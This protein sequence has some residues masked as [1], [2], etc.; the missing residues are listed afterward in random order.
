MSDD[1]A[2]SVMSDDRGVSV[3]LG[4][5]S[6]TA[7][8]DIETAVPEAGSVESLWDW[9]E[10]PAGRLLLVDDT[11]TLVSVLVPDTAGGGQHDETAIWGTG[12][13][14]SLVVVLRAL[15]TWQLEGSPFE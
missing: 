15:F 2:I 6:N 11:R 10:T 4:E 5:M 3:T 1:R 7:S 14:N 9:S 13:N 12:P 8:A